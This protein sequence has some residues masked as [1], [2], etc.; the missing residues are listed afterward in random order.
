MEAA[1][2]YP[3]T[4]LVV[5]DETD[6]SLALGD[7]LGHE[8]YRVEA[9][10]TGNEA[11]RRVSPTHLY[12]AVILDLGLPDM[13]GL[14][15]LQRLHTLDETLPVII[16]TAHGD[17]K[18]KISSL[19]H[20]A[21]AHLI[22]PYDRREVIEMVYRAVAVKNLTLKAAEAVQ[23]LTSSEAQRQLEQQR[24]Q[25]LLSKVNGDSPWR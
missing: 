9:V 6:I 8:G 19:Q 3:P 10:E 21:F 16:L 7:L 2:T 12:S 4:I 1:K 22:K 14:T 11:L 20:H 24:T 23:A 25:A 15:V 5:D 13:D 18:E 17:H